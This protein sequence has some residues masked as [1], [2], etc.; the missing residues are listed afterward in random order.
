MVKGLGVRS[1]LVSETTMVGRVKSE[2]TVCSIHYSL[3]FLSIGV[4]L[5]SASLIWGNTKFAY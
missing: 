2:C 5:L 3:V 4:L 1:Q